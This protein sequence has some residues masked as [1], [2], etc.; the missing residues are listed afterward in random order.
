M[1]VEIVRNAEGRTGYKVL[2]GGGMGRTPYIAQVI[3]DFVEKD[4]HPGL[5]G[6]GAARL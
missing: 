4:R 2:V 6:S 1:A 5:H 3:G